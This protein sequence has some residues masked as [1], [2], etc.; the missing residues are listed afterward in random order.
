MAAHGQD[1]DD[2][3][4]EDASD[5]FEVRSDAGNSETEDQSESNDDVESSKVQIMAPPRNKQT[6]QPRRALIP[7][8]ERGSECYLASDQ[9]GTATITPQSEYHLAPTM[10]RPTDKGA[11]YVPTPPP[12][13]SRV[14]EHDKPRDEQTFIKPPRFEGGDNC[15]ESHLMQF[16]IIAKQNQ[17]DDHE[18]A[19]N[20]KCT[21]SGEASHISPDL[22]KAASYDDVVTKLRQRYGSLE[23][24][25]SFQISENP[26]RSR[27]GR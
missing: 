17:W 19:D 23:Q 26:E 14:I 9:R 3:I 16:K 20:L 21:L 25:E 5:I 11:R 22:E 24:I 8:S 10:M 6:D 18:K 12:R 7:R 13:G 2:D 15:I 4:W 27:A 1:P